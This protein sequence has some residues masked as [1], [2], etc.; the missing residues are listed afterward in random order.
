ML[1]KD[2]HPAVSAII[3]VVLALAAAFFLLWAGISAATLGIAGVI[4][5]VAAGAALASATAMRSQMGFAAGTRA[6][7]YTGMF[8]GHRGE[9]VFNPATGQ[10]TGVRREV[11]GEEM[12]P[13]TNIYD[14]P[15]TIEHV[16]TKADFDDL[17]EEL[18]QALRKGA[19]RRR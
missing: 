19:K 10:P 5:G 16:H 11:F 2:M 9:M 1:L 8:F 12:E 18:G 6:L 7:P 13:R 3:A 14:M 17:D 4:G 15:I